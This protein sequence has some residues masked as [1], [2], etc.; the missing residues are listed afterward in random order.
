MDSKTIKTGDIM[1]RIA[2]LPTETVFTEY[3]MI[4]REVQQNIVNRAVNAGED[5]TGQAMVKMRRALIDD[6]RAILNT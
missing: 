4:L 3:E 1:G 2:D 6:A 5:S